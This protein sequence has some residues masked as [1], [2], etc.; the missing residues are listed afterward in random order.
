MTASELRSW[1]YDVPEDSEVQLL[2]VD[3]PIRAMEP[4]HYVFT[5]CSGGDKQLVLVYGKEKEG[6]EGK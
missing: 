6:K 5:K 2:H 1:L 4:I 3:A